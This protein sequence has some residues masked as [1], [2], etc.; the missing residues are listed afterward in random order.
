MWPFD[1]NLRNQDGTNKYREWL[2]RWLMGGWFRY[3]AAGTL[4]L[5]LVTSLVWAAVFTWGPMG[6]IRTLP[7]LPAVEGIKDEPA[8]PAETILD[9][10]HETL[11]SPGNDEQPPDST[12][13]EAPVE[14]PAPTPEPAGNPGISGPADKSVPETG[15]EQPSGTTA[16][17]IL[18]G[19][20]EKPLAGRQAAGYGL[21]YS[22]RFGD[23]RFN[24]GLELVAEAGTA[25]KAALD[26]QVKA[27]INE[28]YGGYTVVLDHG[29]GWT[30]T[31]TSL[32]TVKVGENQA[33]ETGALL[34]LLQACDHDSMEGRLQ[35]TM[36]RHGEPVDPG[37]YLLD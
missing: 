35:F 30:S 4:V 1:N 13:V 17:G 6:V 15:T 33:V 5:V 36:A 22:E 21:T 25:V 7:E 8:A 10:L 31:Y 19:S 26:G 24:P 3:V 16:A 29:A 14:L 28:P 20:M 18:K 12:A 11:E 2:R 34:G 32:E 27:V 9:R 37:P 23:Y